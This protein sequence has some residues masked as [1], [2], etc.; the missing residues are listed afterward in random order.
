[1][2][3]FL[4]KT[5]RAEWMVRQRRGRYS[6]EVG[7]YASEEEA[8]RQ[9]EI[10]KARELS[11]HEYF[12]F[13]RETPVRIDPILYDTVKSIREKLKKWVDGD[14]LHPL[15]NKKIVHYIPVSLVR[16]RIDALAESIYDEAFKLDLENPN[17]APETD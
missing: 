9:V 10:L 15:K 6:V 2:T 11:R 7:P 4:Y 14:L 17:A 16:R 13:Y 5:V 8:Y 3:G 1:M 12:V